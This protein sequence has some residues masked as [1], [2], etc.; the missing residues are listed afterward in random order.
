MEHDT[1]LQAEQAADG[2]VSE[3]V[4]DDRDKDHCNPPGQLDRIAQPHP[5]DPRHDEELRQNTNGNFSDSE[6]H[7]D[8]RRGAAVREATAVSRRGLAGRDT[9]WL[10]RGPPISTVSSP[11][12][13]ASLALEKP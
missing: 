5:Q 13:A 9:K 2:G 3:L 7:G 6:C 8:R 1:G 11:S 10:A 4:D 12:F